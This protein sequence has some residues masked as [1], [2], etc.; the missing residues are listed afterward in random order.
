[1]PQR[2]KGIAVAAGDG[3]VGHDEG[4]R[5]DAAAVVALDDLVGDVARDVGDQLLARGR[6]FGEVIGE[7]GDQDPQSGR[8]DALLRRAEFVRGEVEAVRIPLDGGARDLD[9]SPASAAHGVEE[10]LPAHRRTGV[11]QDDGGPLL[12]SLEIS[13][14]F[15]EERVAALLDAADPDEAGFAEQ[16]GRGQR[17]ERPGGVVVRADV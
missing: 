5:L 7:C 16:R 8:C 9:S 11:A 2:D 3:G 4:R 12:G 1:M 14:G 6:E 10:L 17:Q 15:G 13:E